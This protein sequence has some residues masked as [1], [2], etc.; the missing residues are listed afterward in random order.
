[1]KLHQLSEDKCFGGYQRVYEH[2]SV[3]LNCRMRFAIYLPPDVE[4]PSP[5]LYHLS[6]MQCNEKT[7]IQKTGY[8][9]WASQYG[10]I[11]VTPDVCPRVTVADENHPIHAKGLSFY[12]DATNEPWSKHYKMYSYVN[13]ELPKIV[14]DNFD[15]KKNRQSIMGHSMGGHGALISALKNPGK[16]CS[17]S[18]FAPVSNPSQVK[19][20]NDLL[21]CYFG[22]DQEILKQWDATCLVSIYEGPE[23]NILIHQ[24]TKDEHEENLMLGNFAEACKKAGITASIN[25][26]EGYSHGAYFISSFVEQHFHHHSKFLLDS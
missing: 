21:K 17:V 24:G 6:G 20:I 14:E 25:F 4:G 18:A 19:A 1:M 10:I 23:L 2:D 15:V 7:F 13:E 22:D 9:R 5:V 11:V 8:Q 3:V 12:V 26:E 16:Y